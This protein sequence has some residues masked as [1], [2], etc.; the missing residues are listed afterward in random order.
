MTWVAVAVVGAAAVGAGASAYSG[1]KASSA[2]TKAAATSAAASKKAT[3]AQLTGQ[4]E[5]LDYLKEVDALPRQ[6]RE[7]ALTQLG[8]T[9]LGPEGFQ[10]PEGQLLDQARNSEMFSM[11]RDEGSD[12]VLRGASATGGLRSGGTSEALAENQ[13]RAL[14]TAYQAQQDQYSM[15]LQGVAS[16][17]NLPLQTGAISNVYG[18]M[19]QTQ[20]AGINAAGQAI[21]QGQVAAGQA[22]AAGIQGV[23]SAIGSG[24]GT[25]G[26]LKGT[27]VI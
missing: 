20:G 21:A 6:Y 4:R 19:A 8:E 2:S 10:Y 25:Y 27:G 15:G 11:L 18:N 13:Q 1:Q 26:Y 22:Q 16:L 9:Y 5:Q 12:A 23:G 14:L 24:I 3:S 17:A 7:Q